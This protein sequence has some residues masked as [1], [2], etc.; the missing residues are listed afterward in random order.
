MAIAVLTGN[1]SLGI[2]KVMLNYY[3]V[4]SYFFFRGAAKINY[5]LNVVILL[6]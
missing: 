6:W 4:L 1:I 3:S 5:I 2:L